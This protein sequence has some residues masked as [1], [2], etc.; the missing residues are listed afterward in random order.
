M[1][2][3]DY[4]ASGKYFITICTKR[5]T[6]WFGDIA[7]AMVVLYTTGLIARGRSNLY[8]CFHELDGVV[9]SSCPTASV[10]LRLCALLLSGSLNS[11]PGS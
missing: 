8:I 1:S 4:S 10:S 5:M 2:G 6:E 11:R 3:Y 7:D 9:T